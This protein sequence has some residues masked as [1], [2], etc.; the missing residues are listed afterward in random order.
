MRAACFVTKI[1]SLE[2]GNNSISKLLQAPFV[3]YLE[4][5]AHLD[6]LAVGVDVA[7]AGPL[8]ELNLQT[9]PRTHFILLNHLNVFDLLGVN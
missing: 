3:S 2:P 1:I 5:L 9:D 7:H 4:V 6:K 8:R